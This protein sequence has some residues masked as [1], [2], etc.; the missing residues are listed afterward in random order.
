MK[1]ITKDNKGI[2]LIVLII[3]II[4]MLI[5]VSVTTFT[6]INAYK[7]SK[8]TQFVTQM[9]LLQSK[10]DDL[11]AKEEFDNTQLSNVTTPIQQ[12]AISSAYSNGEVT[13]NNTT[14]YKV[15]TPEKILNIL[16]VDSV[17]NDI[18]VNF[19]TREIISVS[20]VE[21]QGK[22]YYTQYKL[23]NGQTIVKDKTE[24]NRELSFSLDTSANGLNCNVTISNIKISNGTL[25][26]AETDSDGNSS[27]WK[28]IA[29]N[30]V[31]DKKYTTNIS[32]SGNYT[33][34]IQDNT[35]NANSKEEKI[36][37]TIANEP[38]TNQTVQ[39]YNYGEDSDK[40]AYV[41]KDSK[42]YLWIP[43]FVYK[44][45]SKEIK[46]I[47]GN[48]NVATDNTYI[49]SNDG[50]KLNN[51]FTTSNGTALTGVWIAVESINQKGLN[52]VTLL[53][54]SNAEILNEI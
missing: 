44:T 28:T 45:D 30:T 41:Q 42:N 11:V 35:N 18:L 13:T 23:P 26:Y 19:D 3:T 12:N 1:N 36:T 25:S 27:N 5:L 39:P 29:N 24:T 8:V 10:I 31:K 20:G 40:W 48:S 34:K 9:Q 15:F 22:T 47:K 32:K 51:K 43:R 21:Y 14:E 49:N 4:V 6:G 2:T 37:I 7:N 52:M 53:N 16:E 50:W 46:F 33:F 54:S 38:K 17:Q